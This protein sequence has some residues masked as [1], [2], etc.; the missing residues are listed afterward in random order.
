MTAKIQDIL[1]NVSCWSRG[2]FAED[3]YGNCCPIMNCEAYCFCLNGAILKACNNMYKEVT[4][5]NEIARTV[6][7]E[8]YPEFGGNIW[9][10]N[11]SDKTTFD[12]VFNIAKIVD[13]RRG[14]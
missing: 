11:D 3:V 2:N 4:Q 13:S 6:I 1:K 5:V 7:K 12:Q 9:H 14:L 8:N 10:F